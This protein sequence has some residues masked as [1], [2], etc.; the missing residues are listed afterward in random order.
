MKNLSKTLLMGAVIGWMVSHG[1]NTF[2]VT[3]TMGTPSVTTSASAYSFQYSFTGSSSYH[4]IYI[5]IDR[6]ASTGFTIG[7]QGADFLLENGTLY[8]FTSSS[9]TSWGWT[10]VSSV[11]FSKSSG[12]AKWS[13][14]L[15]ANLNNDA[16][17]NFISKMSSSLVSS[18]SSFSGTTTPTTPADTTA[19]SSAT[20][21]STA[22][23]ASSTN[24]SWSGA[25]D[26]VGVIGY[27][28]YQN[29][30]LKTSTTTTS[31]AV[32]GLSALTA[33]SFYVVAKDAAG[34]L[35]ASSNVL[36]L[37]TLAAADISAP[38]APILSASGITN[39]SANLSWTPS[40]DNVGVTGYNIYQN[41]V[42]INTNPSTSLAITGLSASTA[43]TFYIVA[44]DAAGNL[45]ASSNAL[46]LTTSAPAVVTGL[47]TV[48]PLA[49]NLEF[50]N[51]ERGFSKYSNF[52][53][54]SSKA[55]SIS[56]GGYS[57]T[58]IQIDLS[59]FMTTPIS[60]AFLA[61]YQAMFDMARANG[62]K[63]IMTHK[64]HDNTSCTTCDPAKTVIL[65]HIA[66]LVPYINRNADVV[67]SI[68]TGFIG[69]YGE[70]YYSQYVYDIP[71]RRQI[72]HALLD[73][74]PSHLQVLLR[75]PGQKILLY[76]MTAPGV[77][78]N[79]ADLPYAKRVGHWNDCFLASSSDYGTNENYRL[80]N[81]ADWRDFIGQ[82]VKLSSAP[83]GGETCNPAP[84]LSE[85]ANALVQVNK[86]HWTYINR[87][88]NGAV[89]DGWI[90]N[91]CFAE[92]SRNL[93]YRLRVN[94]IKLPSMISKS[95]SPL[96]SVDL[97]IENI[98]YSA[99][100][101]PRAVKLV[102]F[103]ATNEYSFNLGLDA[104]LWSTGVQTIS[105]S[106]NLVSP[107]V[108]NGV[109]NVALFL[110]DS[111]ASLQN[112]P[113]YA[114]RFA[115]EGAWDSAKGWNVIKD[116]TANIQITIGD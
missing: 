73:G 60:A 99:P 59:A 43:Y 96:L 1:D 114:I 13:N 88:Y 2:A 62:I 26:N 34:N 49:T 58:G 44:K 67:E 14:I 5:D 85:C 90:A 28:V 116:G 109:Y 66:Q 46:S 8:K 102:L 93:G 47:M 52:P 78:A 103:N 79:A 17:F 23:T 86:Q 98:G 69:A 24:L 51:P 31:L 76:N 113:N 27:N 94:E 16:D 9:Q 70:M 83:V 68:H 55:A 30:A 37:T 80:T 45:S 77:V 42:L 12:L 82:D 107:S 112:N 29:G 101:H 110:P 53:L 63:L 104:K 3:S 25:T 74:I 48:L 65:D 4:Q 39:S 20:L 15:K 11:T 32:S 33:Y 64:Y 18:I 95:S 115:N 92:I 75:S 38:S 100:I 81:P 89:Y 61:D 6:A 84:I 108:P 105:K 111:A 57:L 36:S 7:A 50:K 35:S 21:S 22:T 106:L 72:V 97:K 91:G 54:T 71:F 19:P 87:D 40:T 56:S 10:K 41:G